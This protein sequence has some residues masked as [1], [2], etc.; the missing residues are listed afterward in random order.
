LKLGVAVTAVN[1]SKHTVTLSD[2]SELTYS[3]LLV[4]TGGE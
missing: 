2:N 4:A 1:P 3:K